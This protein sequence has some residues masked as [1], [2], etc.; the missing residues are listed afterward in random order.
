MRGTIA[1]QLGGR[2]DWQWPTSGLICEILLP[3][4]R[5]LADA[6]PPVMQPA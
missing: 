3:A 4:E 2:L 6:A 5:V 1:D